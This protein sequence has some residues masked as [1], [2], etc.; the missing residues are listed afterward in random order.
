MIPKPMKNQW[1]QIMLSLT[2]EDRHGFG[3]QRAV[4]DQTD[5]HMRLWP[6][7]LYRSLSTL[8][9]AGMI[10]QID[11]PEK[12]PDDER[13]NYYTLTRV[14]RARLAEE[15]EMMARWVDSARPERPT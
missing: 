5:G 13:R 14:G 6:A 1:F 15:A 4:L 2:E 8:E 3:I 9:G 10:R 12:A 11:P 7:M